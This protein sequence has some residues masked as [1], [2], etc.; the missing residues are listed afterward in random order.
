MIFK[1]D[2][3]YYKVRLS[4]SRYHISKPVNWVKTG[5]NQYAVEWRKKYYRVMFDWKK[6]DKNGNPYQYVIIKK[7][8]YE[9]LHTKN[10]GRDIR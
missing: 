5:E 3:G 6:L 7:L 8:K 2:D 4:L 10:G 1:K 9:V